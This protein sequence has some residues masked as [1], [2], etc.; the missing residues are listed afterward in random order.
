MKVE[1]HRDV[2]NAYATAVAESL[3]G[4]VVI[5]EFIEGSLHSHSAFI[6]NGVIACEFFVDEYCSVYP[7][8]VNSSCVSTCLDDA[9]MD[10]VS[11]CIQELVTDL[12][13]CDGI[14]HT[15]FISNGNAFWLIELTRRCPGDL[16]SQLIQLTTDIPYSTLFT[17]PFL[18]VDI[19]I[20]TKRFPRKRNIA[21]HTVSTSQSSIFISLNYNSSPCKIIDVVPLKKSGESLQEAPFDRAAIIFSEFENL[22]EMQKK[23]P[24]LNEYFTVKHVLEGNIHE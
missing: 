1:D 20:D 8:Q 9:M 4:D 12:S 7:Y 21:R 6:R 5:E 13:L 22:S 10:D 24:N 14:L 18:G 17:A 16:Y 19:P 23:T 3:S 2:N 11:T 15:Q